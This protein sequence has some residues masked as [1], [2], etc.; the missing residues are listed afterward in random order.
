MVQLLILRQIDV[1]DDE[2]DDS[3]LTFKREGLSATEETHLI[4]ASTLNRALIRRLTT[5]DLFA[6]QSSR[7]F[8]P[9]EAEES[10]DHIDF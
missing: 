8:T 3:E 10:F 9:G 6:R 4:T 2:V 1:C 7:C 5:N